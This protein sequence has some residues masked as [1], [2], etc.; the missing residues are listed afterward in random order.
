MAD[1]SATPA[2]GV[3]RQDIAGARPVDG[4]LKGDSLGGVRMTPPNAIS[5][6]P[7]PGGSGLAGGG[8]RAFVGG[9]TT[10]INNSTINNS[11]T[12]NYINNVGYSNACWNPGWSSW[13][14]PVWGPSSCWQSWNCS[15]GFNVGI[16]FGSGG[17]SFGLFYGSC[18]QPFVSSW[19]N[20]WWSGWSGFVSV[21]WTPSWRW[22]ST[23]WSPWGGPWWSGFA[24]TPAFPAFAAPVFAYTPVWVEPA[25][26]VV[27]VPV[28]TWSTPVTTVIY[29]SPPAVASAPLAAP[30]PSA[31]QLAVAEVQ[32]WDLLASGFPRSAAATFAD[33][34][35]ANPN[36]PRPMV[37]YAI[38]LA[39][40]EDLPAAA[41]VLREAVTRDPSVLA[42]LPLGPSLGERLALLERSAEAAARQAASARDALFLLGSIRVMLGRPADANLA[43]IAAQQQGDTSLAASQLRAWL[44]SRMGT[45]A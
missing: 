14:P 8:D 38:A 15:S 29:D 30:S 40:L 45:T 17:W 37:G 28:A 33:V 13:C 9:N 7:A 18:N 5:D 12:V 24:C 41:G 20:P 42:T 1:Q 19:C 43:L 4:Y 6:Y 23:C 32:A 26:T 44:L 27:T 35:G 39:M 25:T 16:G 31:A 21:G 22:S 2:P 36:A 11:S 34:H 10:I 3:V